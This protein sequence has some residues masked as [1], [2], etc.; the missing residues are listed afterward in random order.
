LL[1]CIFTGLIFLSID[2][3]FL[4]S[5]LS[6]LFHGAW[7]PLIIATT[8][9]ILLSTWY[10]GHTI[11]SRERHR[12]EGS[13]RSFVTKLHQTKIPRIDGN[14]VYLGHHVGNAPLALHET[15]EQLHE[16][17]KNVV[18]VTVQTTDTPHV[19]ERSRILFDGLGHP[20]DGISHVTVQ[21][22]YKDAPNVPK[23]LELARQKSPE[24]DFDPYEATYFTSIS[25]PT[26]VHNHRMAKWR[27]LIYLYLDRNASNPSSYYKLPLDHT[28]EMRAFLEL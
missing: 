8:G 19:P 4:S 26:I 28:I 1:S 3:L 7:A 16:L 14:A 9:F 27:K 21:F 10:K 2:T 11:I 17:H 25:Q 18:V 22:G 6:K 5:S 15:M 20:N 12:S 13:L 24:V 23:A